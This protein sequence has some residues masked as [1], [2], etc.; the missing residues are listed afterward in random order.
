LIFDAKL[1]ELYPH[2]RKSALEDADDLVANLADV[3]VVRFMSPRLL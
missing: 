3:R 2:C 1:L